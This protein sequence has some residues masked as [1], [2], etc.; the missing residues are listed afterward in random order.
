MTKLNYNIYTIC[1][2]GA[3]RFE[4]QQSLNGWNSKASYFSGLFAITD[5]SEYACINLSCDCKG[6][7]V[8]GIATE[9]CDNLRVFLLEHDCQVKTNYLLPNSGISVCLDTEF[10]TLYLIHKMRMGKYG[11]SG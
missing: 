9:I 11:Y 7:S 4:F 8:L 5:I 3:N 2:G 10:Y 6:T 1:F